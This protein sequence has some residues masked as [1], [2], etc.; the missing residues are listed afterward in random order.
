MLCVWCLSVP[1]LSLP[2]PDVAPVLAAWKPQLMK[3][4]HASLAC[5]PTLSQQVHWKVHRSK[6]ESRTAF[7]SVVEACAQ[8]PRTWKKSTC[9]Q[10]SDLVAH[11]ERCLVECLHPSC[12]H[13]FPQKNLERMRLSMITIIGPSWHFSP[14]MTLLVSLY[15][16]TNPQEPLYIREFIYKHWASAFSRCWPT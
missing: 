5:L 15:A 16:L 2:Y 7:T 8:V 11:Y 3:S 14:S 12:H 9:C 10:I 6:H 4:A 13:R 1:L